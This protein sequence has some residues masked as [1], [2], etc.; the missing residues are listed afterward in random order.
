MISYILVTVALRNT[1]NNV[2]DIQITIEN[3]TIE[4]KLLKIRIKRI[5]C[6]K[7]VYYTGKTE[8]FQLLV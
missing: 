5:T 8:T 4:N 6:N 7:T 2:F 1:I 3:K